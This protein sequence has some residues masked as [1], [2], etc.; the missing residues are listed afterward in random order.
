MIGTD[1]IGVGAGAAFGLMLDLADYGMFSKTVS[2]KITP[3]KFIPFNTLKWGII[4]MVVKADQLKGN[5]YNA[6]A[7]CTMIAIELLPKIIHIQINP[8]VINFAQLIT[9]I[10][11]I[12][13]QS[14]QTI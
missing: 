6:G 12:Y 14:K 3:H 5:T 13:I 9:G 7:L 11:M 10:G 8:K 4:G 1:L 2:L